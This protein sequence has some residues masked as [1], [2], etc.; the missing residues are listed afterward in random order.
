MLTVD[1]RLYTVDLDVFFLKMLFGFK[2]GI[3]RKH[4]VILY[5]WNKYIR[6]II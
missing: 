1:I 2:T 5:A 6:N 4:I 3:K